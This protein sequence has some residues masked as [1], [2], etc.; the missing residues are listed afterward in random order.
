MGDYLRRETIHGV[1]THGRAREGNIHT[2]VPWD[3][4]ICAK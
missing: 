3:C 4:G 2:G 1:P